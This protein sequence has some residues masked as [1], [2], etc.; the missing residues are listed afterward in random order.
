MILTYEIMVL[1]YFLSLLNLLDFLNFFSS[2]YHFG[3]GY[4]WPNMPYFNGSHLITF[5]PINPTNQF[6]AWLY[7]AHV[8]LFQ[9]YQLKDASLAFAWNIMDNYYSTS[10]LVL[11][12]SLLFNLF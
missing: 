9:D 6:D 2:C 4:W 8:I 3:F 1:L 11:P 7:Y 12:L 5:W 10:P